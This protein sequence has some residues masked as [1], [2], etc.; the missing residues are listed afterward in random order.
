MGQPITNTGSATN[1]QAIQQRQNNNPSQSGPFLKNGQ[2]L[3]LLFAPGHT[4]PKWLAALKEP[5][6]EIDGQK[7]HLDVTDNQGQRKR[8]SS[9]LSFHNMGLKTE[10]TADEISRVQQ[11]MEKTY[12]INKI[13]QNVLTHL[14]KNRDVRIC[15]KENEVSLH[16]K[17]PEGSTAT[18]G[19]ARLRNP[20]PANEVDLKTTR[21]PQQGLSNQKENVKSEKNKGQ[22]LLNAVRER[23]KAACKFVSNIFAPATPIKT[24]RLKTV[25]ENKKAISSSEEQ[26]SIPQSSIPKVTKGALKNTS[27]PKTKG[28]VD[29]Q[30]KGKAVS[31]SEQLLTT[32][33]IERFVMKPLKDE[34]GNKMMDEHGNL[35]FAEI[36][37]YF[38]G[39][40]YKKA[41]KDNV[42]LDNATRK[43]DPEEK[44]G[45]NERYISND[46]TRKN[47]P[48]AEKMFTKKPDVATA[49]KKWQE[50]YGNYK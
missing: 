13:C 6:F 19:P 45:A 9:T 7:I 12:T 42:L 39:E 10:L 25:F 23:W 32:N 48:D 33:E 8:L 41:L 15:V 27:S 46:E 49:N 28:P 26:T 40:E 20:T 34:K 17:E 38:E 29:G 44:V 43:E 21:V 3:T 24:I 31:F 36:S 16:Y 35:L 11:I 4:N 50:F 2:S 1:T 18:A 37:P 5:S 30:G 14:Q 22:A 47:T